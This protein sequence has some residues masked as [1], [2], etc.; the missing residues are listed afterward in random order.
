MDV[1]L[2]IGGAYSG[3]RRVVRK[4]V[5]GGFSWVSAYEGKAFTDWRAS[6]EEKSTLVL[7]GW[8]KWLEDA[9]LLESEDDI[10]RESFIQLFQDLV[11]EEQTRG[12]ETVLVM[13]EIGRGIVP[14]ENRY[15]RLRDLAGW[16]A[17]DAAKLAKEVHYVWHGL[18]ERLK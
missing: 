17:Q 3:K 15:R 5:N 12:E 8:E 11:R 16:I 1:Q 6:W 18:A 2:V 7:E 14:I 10:I 9:I 4:K 13:L